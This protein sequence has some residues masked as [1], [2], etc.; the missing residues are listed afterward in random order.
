MLTIKVKNA[1]N[2]ITFNYIHIACNIW[3][4][5]IKEFHLWKGGERL[6]FKE[7]FNR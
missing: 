4:K 7:A 3:W 1:R 5:I 6:F 2:K